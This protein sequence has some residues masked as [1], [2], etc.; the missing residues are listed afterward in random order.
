MGYLAQLPEIVI[1]TQDHARL[2][3]IAEA[4][5]R[6]APDVADYLLEELDRATL[7]NAAP[8]CA[9]GIKMGSYVEFRDDKTGSVRSV[10]LVFPSEAD[11]SQGK[12]SVLTP[13]GAA[14]IGL[15]EGQSIEWQTRSGDWK[16]LTVLKVSAQ[17]HALGY[18]DT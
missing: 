2:Q 16:T 9:P 15:S 12:I 4:A 18:L 3:N 14:L 5:K 8:N 6:T 17:A 13:I 11:V 7:C 1:S 10:Q